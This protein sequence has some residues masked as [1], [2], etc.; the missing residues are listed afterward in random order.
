MPSDVVSEFPL[1]DEYKKTTG[2]TP[3]DIAELRKWLHTQPHLPGK[4][5]TDLDLILAYHC[6]DRSSGVTKQVLDLHFTLRTLFTTYF[7]DRKVEDM[8][9]TMQCL[10]MTLLDTRSRDGSAIW[11][12]HFMDPDPKVFNFGQAIRAVLMLL[13]LWQYEQGTWPGFVIVI[14]FEHM[15]LGHLAKLDLQNIQQ[16]LYYLQEAILVKLKGLHFINAPSFIDKILLMMRPF[17]KKELMD[18]LCVHQVGSKTLDKYVPMEALPSDAGGS[19]KTTK[20]Y[21]E[22]AIA[23]MNANKEY[24]IFENK[25]RAVEALRPGKPKTISDIFGGV[26]GSFKKLDID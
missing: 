21:H 4:Y 26:E 18:I 16:F 17:M 11:F 20:E 1:E 10:L 2:I 15:S 8:D 24:F 7:K 14:D 5:I 22:A 6:C 9:Q 3:Q 23:K 13:D 25:K 19:C 12:T